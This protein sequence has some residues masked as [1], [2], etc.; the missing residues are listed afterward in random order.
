MSET[1]NGLDAEEDFR[2]TVREIISRLKRLNREVEMEEMRKIYTT[3]NDD[4]I[5]ALKV[6]MQLRDEIKS[7]IGDNN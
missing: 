1:F 7:R 3:V 2:Q 5:E 4:E 6:Q